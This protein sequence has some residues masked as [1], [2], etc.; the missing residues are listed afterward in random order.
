MRQDTQNP[1]K[2][3]L[4]RS[5]LQKRQSLTPENWQ[6]SSIQ[7][8]Q[9]LQNSSVFAE[10]RTILAFFSFR[11]EP[12]LHS[13]FTAGKQWGFSRCIGE[14]LIWH[15]WSPQDS[16][17]LQIGAYG[18]LEPHPDAPIVNPAAVDLILVPAVACDRSGYRLGYGGGFY[19]RMLSSLTWADK[20]TLGIIF[21]FARL[22]SLPIDPW[23][24]P[25]QGIC[26]E[27]GC[28]PALV[29]GGI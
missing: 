14:S 27:S 15:F 9:H 20:P 22:A 4:R 26:T 25:L 5:L 1:D 10:A 29:L 6:Q 24:H 13:L 18:I 2:R 3:E 12:D 17:P 8:C 16:L 11:Q 28:Y 19:D 21:E 7:L 23:D